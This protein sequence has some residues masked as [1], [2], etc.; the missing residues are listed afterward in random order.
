MNIKNLSTPDIL[1]LEALLDK[2]LHELS[3]DEVKHIHARRDYLL[4][5]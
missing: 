5:G 1:A 3:V 4:E 2:N